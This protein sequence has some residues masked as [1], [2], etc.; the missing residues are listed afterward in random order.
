[1]TVQDLHSVE[2]K[3]RKYTVL[4]QA[5]GLAQ[6]V[7][8]LVFLLLVLH[9]GAAAGLAA[10]LGSAVPSAGPYLAGPLIVGAVEL[11]FF[12]V[13]FPLIFYRSFLLDHQF[14]L[15]RQ[16]LAGWARDQFFAAVLAFVLSTLALW[17]FYFLAAYAPT[18]W[19]LWLAGAYTCAQLLLAFDAPQLIVPLFFTYKPFSRPHLAQRILA[20]A[21]RMRLTLSLSAICEID[22]GRKTAKVNA[23]LVGWGSSR[24]GIVGD[25][26]TRDFTDEE[27]LVI[28]AH[29]FAHEKLRHVPKLILFQSGLAACALAAAAFYGPPVSQL[30]PADRVPFLMLAAA[31]FGLAAGPLH[32]AFSRYCER[33]ADHA[34]LQATGDSA[35]FI[36]AM[37][38]LA[39]RNFSPLYCGRLE[40]I[41]FYDHPPAAERIARA[42]RFGTE[43]Q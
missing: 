8:F 5:L 14:G 25:T 34:A 41:I 10:A 21:Q 23:G 18:R 16:P 42:R 26:L 36:G 33:Q 40:K 31:C 6:T 38:R 43:G 9:S 2:E 39:E 19:W 11:V 4:R 15:S 24:R 20:L 22:L 35:S 1:M 7:C 30:L 13:F 27:I 12:L 17:T 29:E 32:N 37:Q 28:L 3:T